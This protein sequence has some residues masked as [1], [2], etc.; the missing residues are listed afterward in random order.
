[1]KKLYLK[2]LDITVDS[3]ELISI[4]GPNGCGKTTLLKMLC[5]RLKNDNIFIDGKNINQYDL[6]Y[7]RKNIVCIF[8]DNIYRT[9][10]PIN[11]LKYYLKILNLSNDE[12][13]SRIKNFNDYFKLDYVLNENFINLNIEKR[14]FIKILSLLIIMPNIFCVDDLFTY[15]NKDMKMKVFNYIKENNITLISITSN[16]EELCLFDKTLVINKGKK[17]IFDITKN[18][19]KREDIFKELGLSLPFI[20]DINNMLK[21]YELIDRDHLVYKELVD[22]LWK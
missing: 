18:I 7:K 1:M 13:E 15:L 19:L 10:K 16:M 6:E 2:N 21:S 11:E 8:D 20:Y 17:I 22:V 12:I 9:D 14:I 4:I 5:G 3:G